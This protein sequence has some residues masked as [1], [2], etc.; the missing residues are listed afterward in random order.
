VRHFEAAAPPQKR[1]SG[2]FLAEK[3]MRAELEWQ[4][5]KHNMIAMRFLVSAHPHALTT[6][7]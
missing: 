4:G 1:F 7:H 3:A 5:S 6:S 2:A